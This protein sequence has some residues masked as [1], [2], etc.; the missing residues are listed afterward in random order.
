MRQGVTG[1]KANLY[2]RTT[3][4]IRYL[5]QAYH[6]SS[7]ILAKCHELDAL[8]ATP[9]V[10]EDVSRKIGMVEEEIKS[11]LALQEEIKS[12][13]AASTQDLRYRQVL[14]MRYV[15]GLTMQEAAD[16]LGYA[17]RYVERLR[18]KALEAFEKYLIANGIEH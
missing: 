18:A 17:K 11:L 14:E 4:V 6:A 12:Q 13:I 15:N 9:D 5:L 10:S 3:P 16:N 8:K 2:W 7:R 1:K